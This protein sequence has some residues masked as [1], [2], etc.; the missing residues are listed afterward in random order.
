M[1]SA[2]LCAWHL[3]T[4]QMPS[5]KEVIV[6]HDDSSEPDIEHTVSYTSVPMRAP[7]YNQNLLDDKSF[8]ATA[9]VASSASCVANSAVSITANPHTPPQALLD[10]TSGTANAEEHNQPRYMTRSVVQN[11]VRRKNEQL[12]IE[13]AS[14]QQL[15]TSNLS[16]TAQSGMT[17]PNPSAFTFTQNTSCSHADASAASSQV[18]PYSLLAYAYSQQHNQTWTSAALYQ[19][20]RAVAV[21]ADPAPLAKQQVSNEAAPTQPRKKQRTLQQ[22]QSSQQQ[23][24][25]KRR[26]NAAATK[27][28][29]PSQRGGRARGTQRSKQQVS[30]AFIHIMRPTTGMFNLLG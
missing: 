11:A 12:I 26:K 17:A 23:P 6:I 18:D 21:A 20:A 13:Q 10:S 24:A 3:C 14:H 27:A 5:P 9:T 4:Q 19:A 7:A 8:T 16:S 28:A 22:P 30:N 1:T 15:H 2:G 29:A 25:V